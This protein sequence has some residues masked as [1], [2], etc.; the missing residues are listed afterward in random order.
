MKPIE[1]S[2][3][4]RRSRSRNDRKKSISRERNNKRDERIRRSKSREVVKRQ[5]SPKRVS[6]SPKRNKREPTRRDRSVTPQRKKEKSISPKRNKRSLTPKIIKQNPVS[7]R[8][9]E[10]ERRRDFSPKRSDRN[11]RRDERLQKTPP[12]DDRNRKDNRRSPIKNIQEK[13]SFTPKRSESP[14]NKERTQYLKSPVSKNTRKERSRSRSKVTQ[15]RRENRQRSRSN[16]ST[17]SYSPARQNPE[18][19]KEILEQKSRKRS[20]SA[21]RTRK[22]R[23]SRSG[24]DRRKIQPVVRLHDSGDDSDSDRRVDDYI[25]NQNEKRERERELTMLKALKSDLAAKAKETIEKKRTVVS[26][27]PI[28]NKEVATFVEKAREIVQTVARAVEVAT[29]LQQSSNEKNKIGIKPFKI[30][31]NN[32]PKSR[33]EVVEHLSRE[34]VKEK[35]PEEEK[36][37]VAV[38][39]SRSKSVS[40][41]E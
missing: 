6:K 22:P 20:P 14:K 26:S 7:S 9:D 24:G 37:E 29:S 30:N 25:S 8:N 36:V 13:R 18:R 19:Y 23:R 31:E 34:M 15:P 33:R 17:L 1:I 5:R 16:S 10:R 35:S 38:R 2:D 32:S 28:T 39:K 27:A 21:D 4:N 41:N 11:E 40:S 3:R 12:R